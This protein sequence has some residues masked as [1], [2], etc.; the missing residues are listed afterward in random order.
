MNSIIEP[1][2]AKHDKHSDGLDFNEFVAL[3]SDPGDDIYGQEPNFDEGEED[4]D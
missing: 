1:L 4:E 3:S 2:L